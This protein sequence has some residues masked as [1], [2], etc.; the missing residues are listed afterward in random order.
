MTAAEPETADAF[1]PAATRVAWAVQIA[2]NPSSAELIAA[3]AG[4]SLGE[5]LDGLDELAG[6]TPPDDQPRRDLGEGSVRPAHLVLARA[7]GP[8]PEPA[9]IRAAHVR[10]AAHLNAVGA[11]FQE[12]AP[13]LMESAVPGDNAAARVL[14]EAADAELAASPNRAEAWAARAAAL[15]PHGDPAALRATSVRAAALAALGRAAEAR[16]LLATTLTPR[17]DETDRVAAAVECAR[18]DRLQGRRLDASHLLTT[19]LGRTDRTE[20][21]AVL[22]LELAKTRLGERDFAEAGRWAFRAL[23]DSA[24][25]VVKAGALG[26][27]ALTGLF[28]GDTAHLGDHAAHAAELMDG[29]LDTEVDG[30]SDT[31]AWVGWA[32]LFLGLP[33]DAV[34]HFTRARRTPHATARPGRAHQLA[35]AA[36]GL[37]CAHAWSGR[38]DEA[39]RTA[40]DAHRL[41]QLTGSAELSALSA[42]RLSQIAGIRGDATEANRAAKESRALLDN[43]DGWWPSITRV[44]LAQAS[45]EHHDPAA[46]HA[47]LLTAAG[48]PGLP[49]LPCSM[50]PYWYERLTDANLAM[51]NMDTARRYAGLAERST[52]HLTLPAWSAYAHL[53][54]A[55]LRLAESTH[56]EAPASAEAADDA[57]RA[58]RTFAAVR[59]RLPE[60]RSRLVAGVAL[61]EAGRLSEARA[62]LATARDLFRRCGAKPLHERAV[63]ELRRLGARLPR[64]RSGGL[65][66]PTPREAEVAALVAQ[67]LTNLE[68]AARLRLSVKT[69]ETHL[70]RVFAKLGVRG[71]VQ[72]VEV[73]ADRTAA[74]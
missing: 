28:T 56:P 32:E 29:A 58:A 13:H 26:L 4:L 64:P 11:P 52:V 19:E 48:G 40:L 39:W 53:A 49:A 59:L 70:S 27:L 46:A 24:D 35:E 61:S 34:R 3:A 62:E 54:R 9:W 41:A 12:Q 20:N 44:V 22:E 7:D 15:L 17:S 16:E 43:S 42:A 47:E 37:A 30:R 38:L 6:R 55:R 69:V 14:I 67:G 36:L 68:I 8:S 10:A 5:A 65:P 31:V 33:E 74:G 73:L 71:R 18:H 51:K 23:A 60:A 1:S 50:H 57:L 66:E 21:R 2:G 63:A 45:P 25:R 72:L